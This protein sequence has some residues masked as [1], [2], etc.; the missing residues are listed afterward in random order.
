MGREVKKTI[1]IL[2]LILTV[3]FL[4][5][6]ANSSSYSNVTVSEAK[7]MIDSN[8]SLVILDVRTISEYDSGH[9]RNAKLIP[10]TELPGRLHELNATDYIL[11]YCLSGGRSSTASQILVDNGFTNVYNMLGGITAWTNAGYSVYIRFSSI[12]GAINGAGEG[13]E[14]YVSSGTYHENLILNKTV[15]LSGENKDDTIIYGDGVG[16][17]VEITANNVAFQGFTVKNSSLEIGTSYAGIKISGANGCRI[18]ENYIIENRLGIF[19]FMSHK[20]EIQN[21]IVKNN[22]QGIVLYQSSEVNV[23]G[24]LASENNFGISLSYCWNNLIFS[25]RVDNSSTGGHGIFISS[26][27]SNNTVVDNEFV[28][29]YHGMWISEAHSNSFL[30]NSITNNSLLGI[31]LS[32]SSDNFFFHNNFINNPR[33]IVIDNNS[34]N[35]W[36]NNCE[37]N[38]WD[39]YNG[40]DSNNDGI[41]ETEYTIHENNTDRYPLM[42]LCW[43]PC[44]INHDWKVDM[45]DVGTTARSFQT[46]PGDENWNCHADVTGPIPLKPDNIVDMRDIGLVARSFGDTYQ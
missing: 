12:Q 1:H 31:E 21:N 35:V 38:Y 42:N 46:E 32:E 39:N 36:D 29:N 10:V 37:G 5:N 45:R 24:N 41:G 44:D 33:H 17:V 8:P 26:N 15:S 40:S 28:D 6:Q 3:S 11:V 25:N 20:T 14:L 16:T 27:S 43:N 18:T 9:I 2:I 7:A 13:A 22:H 34:V 19:V 23:E 30:R 4:F